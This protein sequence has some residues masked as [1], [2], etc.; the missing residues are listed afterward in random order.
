MTQPIYARP[1]ELLQRLIQ[2][3]TTNPPGNE[4]DCISYLNELL[5][6]AGFQ[7]TLLAKTPSRPNLI[8][9]LPGRG[10]AP[11]LVLQGHV[12]VVTTANQSWAHPPFSGNLVDGYI[13]GRGALDMKGGVVMMLTAVLR[14]QAEGFQPAGDVV[15][16]IMPTRKRA[17][18]TGRAFWWS[19]TRNSLPVS[20]MPLA[21]VAAAHRRSLTN[22][23]T[24][25]W[26]P[27]RRSAGCAPR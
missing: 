22:A 7:T 19:N 27:K 23:T 10:A 12:D 9:R 14:A 20:A 15:L 25:S 17:A 1:A 16:T 26:W 11:G 4:A 3:D 5:T 8:A 21:R 24:R 13:W 6:A 18:T 2:F